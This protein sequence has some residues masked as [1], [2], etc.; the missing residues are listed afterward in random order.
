MDSVKILLVEDN[1]INQKLA[2]LCLSKWGMGVTIANHGK[3]ALNLIQ[4]RD[5]QLVLMD[6][7]MPEMDGYESTARIRAMED[8]YFKT[9]PILAFSASSM[10][11]SREKAMAFGMTDFVNKPL[12]VE[13]LQDK[14]NTYVN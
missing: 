4:S 13:E 11:D 7:Q 9:V 1:V 14:I 2:N 12:L 8:P 10:I 3:E 5:F 6:L